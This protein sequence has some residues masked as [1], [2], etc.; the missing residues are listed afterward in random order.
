MVVR[1][2]LQLVRLSGTHCPKTCGMQSVQTVDEDVVSFCD[3]SVFSALEVCY[4]NALYKFTF[5]TDIDIAD[6]LRK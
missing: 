3:T 6:V 4:K 1:I 5:D 2:F